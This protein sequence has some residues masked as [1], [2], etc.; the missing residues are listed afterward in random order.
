MKNHLDVNNL[1]NPNQFGF[2]ANRSTQDALLFST[3]SWRNA[4]NQSKYVAV[5]FIDLSK[6]FD[7]I[8][9]TLLINKLDSFGFH[10]TAKLLIKS[11]LENRIQ[12]VC[13]GNTK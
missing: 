8:D 4:L 1:L 2:R 3:E 6:A 11:Y 10:N 13:M 9:H 5:A 12:R 7:S